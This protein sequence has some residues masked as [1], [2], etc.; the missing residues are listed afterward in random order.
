MRKLELGAA[1]RVGV[2][3]LVPVVVTNVHASQTERW[4]HLYASKEP[5]AVIVLGSDGTRFALDTA[6]RD[7]S[8]ADLVAEAPALEKTLRDVSNP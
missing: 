6:G 1:C 5:Y 2:W 3:T 4:R 7:V 8:I